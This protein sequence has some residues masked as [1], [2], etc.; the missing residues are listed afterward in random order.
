MPDTLSKQPS[1]SWLYDMSF[2]PRLAVGNDITA[3]DAIIQQEW[4]VETGTASSTVDLT[5]TGQTFAAR[6]AQCRIAGGLHGKI[7]LITF[8]VTAGANKAEAEG[9]LQVSNVPLAA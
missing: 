8:Q 9:F 6:R 4:N 1:E 5:I 3:I 2:E 7:Y